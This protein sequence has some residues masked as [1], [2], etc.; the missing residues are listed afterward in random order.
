V[1]NS[2]VACPP[3]TYRQRIGHFSEKWIRIN[4]RIRIA[5][6]VSAN[7]VSRYYDSIQAACMWT[8]M[9]LA[10]RGQKGEWEAKREHGGRSPTSA[11]PP[12]HDGGPQHAACL[13]WQLSPIS[14]EITPI[15]DS[16]AWC[17][18]SKLFTAQ[19]LK[20]F[21]TIVFRDQVCDAVYKLQAGL[22][23]TGAAVHGPHRCI[24]RR[25]RA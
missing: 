4:T 21:G 13:T 20:Q 25:E 24:W 22:H 5:Y 15:C 2:P 3:V 16:R 10:A 6:C 18:C 19:L 23:P 14:R 8:P 17:Q 7:H 9:Q 1:H 11:R 12:P